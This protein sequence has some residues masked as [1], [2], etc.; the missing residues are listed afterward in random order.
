M[1]RRESVLRTLGEDWKDANPFEIGT[2]LFRRILDHPEGVEIARVDP[3]TNLDD[4][5][6]WDD[7][8]VRMAPPELLGEVGRAIENDLPKDPDY[9]LVL[10]AGLRTRWTAN[11][12]QR[13]PEWRKGKGPHCP[14]HLAPVDAE[15]LGIG[16]GD[17]VRIS[18]RRGSL[19]LPA[20]V[21][22]KVR[23]GHVWI[24]N[25]FGALYPKNGDG[26][27]EAI[28]VNTNELT[29]VAD[30]DPISGCPHHKYTLCRVE[31]VA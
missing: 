22:A 31:R 23:A 9:P 15:A 26:A 27:L 6:G 12:I 3:A 1:G 2:E 30:R 18:T 14:L 4:N 25:G 11:T 5:I 24:P 21:D 8:R 19:E 7:G 10:G 20:E 28:G 13:R 17:P 16:S 29:D